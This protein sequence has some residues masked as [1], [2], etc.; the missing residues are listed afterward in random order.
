MPVSAI[1]TRGVSTTRPSQSSGG[2]GRFFIVLLAMLAVGGGIFAL[3][4]FLSDN[5]KTDDGMLAFVPPD[6]NL[7][8]SVE[9]DQ[10]AANAKLKEFEENLPG[11]DWEALALIDKADMRKNISHLVVGIR[12]FSPRVFIPVTPKEPGAVKT[13]PAQPQRSVSPQGDVASMVFRTKHPVDKAKLISASS[14]RE[15]KKGDKTYYIVNSTDSAAASLKF[16][17]PSDTLIVFTRNDKVLEK[18]IAADPGKSALPAEMQSLVQRVSRGPIWFAM[19]RRLLKEPTY[20][21]LKDEGNCPFLTEDTLEALKH[22]ESIG[23]WLKLDGDHVEFTVRVTCDDPAYA[24]R[25]ADKGKHL[26]SEIRNLP[27]NENTK[28]QAYRKKYPWKIVSPALWDACVEIQRTARVSMSGAAIEIRAECNAEA[29]V[30]LLKEMAIN[31]LPPAPIPTEW[32]K[33]PGGGGP[34]KIGKK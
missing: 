31:R 1:R 16:F 25:V 32:P 13:P 19:N 27:I 10:L 34:G 30:P 11:S 7:I 22:L 23:G 5:P 9:F 21:G 17:F 2:A 33:F 4:H 8:V 14:G 12:E 24:M 3:I 26:V 15:A 28:I 20:L 29:I 6:S 18:I